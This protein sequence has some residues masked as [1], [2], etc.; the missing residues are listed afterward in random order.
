MNAPQMLYSCGLHQQ[1]NK[2]DTTLQIPLQEAIKKRHN[3]SHSP[4]MNQHGWPCVTE[5]EREGIGVTLKNSPPWSGI[6]L[7]NPP[8]SSVCWSGWNVLTSNDNRDETCQMFEGNMCTAA[9]HAHNCHRGMCSI[10]GFAPSQQCQ[11]A[12]YWSAGFSVLGAFAQSFKPFCSGTKIQMPKCLWT[13]C[14]M[15]RKWKLLH[16]WQI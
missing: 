6:S 1:E 14:K 12:R 16:L 3:S 13:C 9:S 7:H 11:V 5:R 4:W 15:K 10:C 8:N 2:S